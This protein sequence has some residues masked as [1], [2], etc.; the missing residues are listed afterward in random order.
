MNF[1]DELFT[2]LPI[3]PS[4]LSLSRLSLIQERISG[5]RV[6]CLYMPRWISPWTVISFHD[7]G[8]QFSSRR[9]REEI[10]NVRAFPPS[11]FLLDGLLT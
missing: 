1:K 6:D 11:G 10:D 3:L 8:E 7:P 9:A 2:D 5:S 4:F